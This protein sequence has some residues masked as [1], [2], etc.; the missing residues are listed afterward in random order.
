MRGNELKV[1]VLS[2]GSLNRGY[3]SATGTKIFQATGENYFSEL[4]TDN[5]EALCE[6]S[7]DAL[8]SR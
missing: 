7:E 2:A 1:E 4:V 5:V 8:A 3:L 6:L